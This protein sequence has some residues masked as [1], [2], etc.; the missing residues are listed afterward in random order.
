MTT[1]TAIESPSSEP[2][3]GRAASEPPHIAPTWATFVLS[4]VNNLGA[5]AVLMAIY[6]V[7]KN[8][9]DF[10]P[11]ENL[12]L[13]LL[14]GGTYI[15]GALS[16]GPGVRWFARRGVSTRGVLALVLPAMS[17]LAVLPRLVPQEWLLWLVVGGFSALSGWLWPL[18]ES[19]LASGRTDAALRKATGLFNIGWASTQVVTFWLMSAL[20]GSADGAL[21]AI[22]VLGMSHVVSLPL[23]LALP[24]DPSPHAHDAPQNHDAAGLR[25]LLNGFRITIVLSY[26]LYSTLN[27]LM[28]FIMDELKIADRWE[29]ALSTVWMSAR[30]V[31]FAVMQQWHGWHGRRATLAAALLLLLCGFGMTLLAPT[32][33]VLVVG[34]AVLGVGMGIV[35]CG[36]FHYAM[37]VG[38]AGVDAGSKHEALIGLGYTGG[39][40][41]S[42]AGTMLVTAGVIPERAEHG[43]ILAAVGLLALIMTALA[44]R[45]AWRHGASSR[46]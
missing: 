36:A 2:T 17:A 28:P 30:V 32:V 44:A 20:S 8:R 39:P 18:I 43:A 4:C 15:G 5:A 31:M 37:E 3:A 10:S 21:T 29:Y 40:T 12:L 6:F 25:P 26:L 46:V 23:L 1:L 45:A 33:G 42:L 27:P 14:Q 38:S 7:T 34:L 11:Q 24:R 9:F 16:S 41:A 19:Y 13:G 35:Y 22:A